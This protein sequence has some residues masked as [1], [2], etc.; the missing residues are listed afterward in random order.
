[1]QFQLYCQ[2]SGLLTSVYCRWLSFFSSLCWIFF[3]L[4]DRLI[5]WIFLYRRRFFGAVHLTTTLRRVHGKGCHVDLIFGALNQR[6]FLFCCTLS[7][8]AKF[9]AGQI[10]RFKA[11]P[12]MIFRGHRIG[13][14]KRLLQGPK[15]MEYH[16]F[17]LWCPCWKGFVSFIHQHY[18]IACFGP[19]LFYLTFFQHNELIVVLFAAWSF[20]LLCYL[21]LLFSQLYA[22]DLFTGNVSD[23]WLDLL[24]D[25]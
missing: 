10:H 25:S 7:H 23:T 13:C 24:T 14:L 21:S 22:L 18:T 11:Q 4:W 9:E 17:G 1:M 8:F 19:I 2:A 16:P 15:Y 3:G 5:C 12:W 20:R 6:I